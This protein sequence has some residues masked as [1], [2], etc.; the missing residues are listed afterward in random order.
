MLLYPKGHII[1]P[2]DIGLVISR[3]IK[4]AFAI[5]NQGIQGLQRRCCTPKIV[6][7]S[8]HEPPDMIE[9]V[10]PVESVI[11]RWKRTGTIT[12]LNTNRDSIN[13]HDKVSKNEDLRAFPLNPDGTYKLET[14]LRSAIHESQFDGSNNTSNDYSITTNDSNNIRKNNLEDSLVPNWLKKHYGDET[15]ASPSG[16]EMPTISS[17]IDVAKKSLHSMSLEYAAEKLLTWPPLSTYGQPHPVVLERRADII[18]KDLK[19]K[20]LAIVELTEPHILLCCQGTWPSHLFY[21][22]KGLR[23]PKNRHPPIVI[24]FPLDPSP[25]QWGLVG[26]FKNVFLIKGSPIFE[27]DLMRGGV[28]QAGNKLSICYFKKKNLISN[29]DFKSK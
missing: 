14:Q 8:Y 19:E 29:F 6:Q 21:F 12:T 13:P 11:D 24:L 9:I 20:T 2:E 22:I 3:N 16:I 27:L 17:T 1:E 23:R 15:Q 7:K 10:E 28:L 5:S 4:T 26:I 25:E 18:L